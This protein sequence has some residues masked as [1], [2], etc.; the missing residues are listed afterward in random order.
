MRFEAQSAAGLG[1][2]CVYSPNSD[3][4][5][6]LLVALLDQLDEHPPHGIMSFGVMGALA[7]DLECGQWIVAR[8]VIDAEGVT[9]LTDPGWSI[10]LLRLYRSARYAP[11]ISSPRAL[12]TPH[13]KRHAY[14]MTGA[15]AVDMESHVVARVA[16]RYGLPF[17]VAR[18][19]LDRSTDVIPAVALAGLNADG[20]THAWPVIKGLMKAPRELWP[21]LKLARAAN[22]ARRALD[23]GRASFGIELGF[24]K[25]SETD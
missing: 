17:V 19:V 4:L 18:V 21:L 16:A 10:A 9:R 11:V 25:P 20:T 3:E 13:A 2:A 7:P 24:P 1:I 6:R 22:R 15:Y 5:E 23:Q 12:L 14:Q 8:S